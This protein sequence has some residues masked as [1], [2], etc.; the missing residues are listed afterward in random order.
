MYVGK[1]MKILIISNY[2]YISGGVETTISS[3]RPLLEARGH[4]VRILTS[5]SNLDRQH[6]NDY[7]FKQLP[8]SGIRKLLYT[9]YNPSSKK[10]LKH[11]LSE[12]NPDAIAIYSMYQATAS[13]LSLVKDFPT[14][15]YVHGPE[16]YI[17]PWI[18]WYVQRRHFRD[19][20]GSLTSTTPIGLLHYIYFSIIC[21]VTYSSLRKSITMFVALSSFTK[22]ILRSQNILAT[23]IPNAAHLFK[24]QPIASDGYEILYVGRLESY[25]GVDDLLKAMKIIKKSISDARLIIVGE[26]QY[27]DQLKQLTVDLDL[28]K[29]VTFLPFQNT[30]E[31]EKS[32]RNACLL[33]MPSAYP[34]TF[35]KV[36]VEAMS[37]GRPVIACDVGGVRDWL[38]HG[39]N[40]F[41]V[42]EHQPKQIAQFAIELL[43]NKQKLK[44]MGKS[45][46]MSA[47]KF[48]IEQLADNMEGL[49]YEAISSWRRE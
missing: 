3:I 17:K 29:D 42:D 28:V 34:E 20:S 1:K 5:D 19:N 22:S 2:G 11:I 33:V 15:L 44:A 41:L 46:S 37:I 14:L 7:S 38:K 23:Y 45:A 12:Y 18:K 40:G 10:V 43:R 35:G 30:N 21:K 24:Y 36:G 49:F 4:E 32:Y 8:K 27:E 16:L 13:I 9:A 26:G 6:F 39:V 25:K 48:S 31:L 47:V